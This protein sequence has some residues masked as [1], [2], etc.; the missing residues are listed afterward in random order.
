MVKYFSREA[1][2]DWCLFLLEDGPD[3]CPADMYR[4]GIA[5]FSSIV[6]NTYLDITGKPLGKLQVP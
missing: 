1:S 4:S 5:W 2:S 6:L 3:G